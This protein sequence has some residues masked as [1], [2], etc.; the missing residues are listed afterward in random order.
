M[1]ISIFY[2]HLYQASRQRSVPVDQ[3]LDEARALGYEGLECDSSEI[4][5][6][7]VAFRRMTDAAGFKVCS[8]PCHFN[9]HLGVA[10]ERIR[11]VI[12]DT[13]AVGC[14]KILAIPG[15]LSH[16]IPEAMDRMVQGLEM[17]CVQAEKAG[18]T[19]TL[20]DFDNKMSHCATAEGL[21][22]LFT[23]IPA[24]KFNLDT[25]NFLYM[26]QDVTVCTRPVLD[27][28]AH[29]HLKDRSLVPMHRLE[30]P[31]RSVGGTDLYPCP[32]GEG[33]IPIAEVLAMAKQAGYDGFCTVEH[34]DAADQWDYITRSAAWLRSLEFHLHEN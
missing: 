12:A 20:E 15:Y 6:D 10:P 5:A 31:L 14:D 19:V 22:A 33:I 1:K 4:A 32:V 30:K 13:L 9:F 2:A 21:Q 7:A 26:E 25:G 3:V 16:E 23:R 8:V 18:I 17:L 28:L 34:F 11:K 27:R 29:M 24:L